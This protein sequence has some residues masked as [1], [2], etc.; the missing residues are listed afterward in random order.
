MATPTPKKKACTNKIKYSF[1]NQVYNIYRIKQVD[2][3]IV[4]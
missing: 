1:I 4:V 3:N 2:N